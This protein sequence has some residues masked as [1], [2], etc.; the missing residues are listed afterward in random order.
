MS[1]LRLWLDPCRSTESLLDEDTFP[2]D[3]L[4][5]GLLSSSLPLDEDGREPFDLADT[6]A[7]SALTLPS[8]SSLAELGREDLVEFE[9][10][11][12]ADTGRVVATLGDFIET[13][14]SSEFERGSS[15]GDFDLSKSTV[16][17]EV[18]LDDLGADAGLA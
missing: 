1:D 5:A 11:L 17:A 15:S 13:C 12:F 6:G 7:D 14:E 10:D 18:G 3:G 9:A 16:R 4:D 8:I 2:E